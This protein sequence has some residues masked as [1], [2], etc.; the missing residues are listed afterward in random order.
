MNNQPWT[1][2]RFAQ[3]FTLLFVL[4]A[5]AP[6]GFAEGNPYILDGFV[7]PDS[8]TKPPNVTVSSPQNNTISTSKD[9]TLSFNAT[10]SESPNA[11]QTVLA[12]ISYKADWLQN[13]TYLYDYGVQSGYYIDTFNHSVT[14]KDVP[15]GNRS[16]IVYAESLGWYSSGGLYIKG[17]F[18]NQSL[19]VLFTVDTLLPTV[20]ISINNQSYSNND[21]TLN[22]T[23]N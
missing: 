4:L 9:I 10:K 17:F 20:S 21:I 11:I 12:R 1:K 19:A 22:I 8:S 7:P 16:L 5:V 2:K 3:L 18:I 6:A 15:E 23:L 14:F 13:T